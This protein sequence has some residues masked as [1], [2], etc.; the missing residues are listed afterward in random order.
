ML[1]E[2]VTMSSDGMDPV[3]P[4]DLIYRFASRLEFNEDTLKV[5]ETAVRLVQRMSIDWMVMGRRPSG[6]CGAC[7]IMAA[8][9]HNYR[10]TVKE[11]VYIVK[12]TTATIQKRM[13][14]FK[15]TASSEL[16]VEEFLGNE[17][18]EQAHDPPSFYQRTEA[19]LANKKTRKRKH[20]RNDD[21]EEDVGNEMQSTTDGMSR[22][23]SVISEDAE[24][25]IQRDADGFVVPAPPAPKEIPIDP[26][27][28]EDTENQAA[29]ESLVREHGDIVPEAEQTEEEITAAKSIAQ[30]IV[31]EEWQAEEE[32][33]EAEINEEIT[34]MMNDPHTVEHAKAFASA[35]QRARVTSMIANIQNPS[36][37]I[38]MTAD[39][40]DTEFAN[41]PEVLHCLLSPEESAIKEKIW[42]N[43]NDD[44][45]R[46]QQRKL[47]MKKIAD[48][49]PKITRKRNKKPRIGEGQLTAASS[50]AEA[51]VAVMK[52]RT[53][54]KR[55]NYD[56][57]AGIF[58]GPLSGP[59]S[60]ATSRVTSV[61]GSTVGASVAGSEAASN[62]QGSE[63]GNALLFDLDEDEDEDVGF[64]PDD[65]EL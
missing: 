36:K 21:D 65:D 17:F 44:W 45:L 19:Y 13:E 40:E 43:A 2:K 59:G 60:A 26:A 48:K 64:D 7:L 14:E 24:P 47:Y 20:I 61:A 8:R 10:R 15:Q 18:L 4:E 29:L 42:L 32:E 34:E 11:V 54:S 30:A 41:D 5:A 12:V 27:L 39:I 1:H 37:G 25:E 38:P 28:L 53:W 46:D 33:I 50:P 35:E 56:A 62:A 51:A 58:D 63:V 23:G 57:I 52:N 31:D 3:I 6:I 16:T 9:I 49:T 55:I 22:L